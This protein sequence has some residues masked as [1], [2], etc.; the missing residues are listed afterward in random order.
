MKFRLPAVVAISLIL[1]STSGWSTEAKKA[2]TPET[3]PTQITEPQTTATP[4]P[5]PA[6]VTKPTPSVEPV[7]HEEV[8]PRATSSEHLFGLHAALSVPHPLSAGLD[9]VHSSRYFSLGVGAGSFGL[10]ISDTDVSIK[11]TEFALRW[12]PFAG[13]FYVGALLGNQNIT[14]EKTE[15]IQG[16]TIIGK[17]EV[18]SS[19]ITPNVGWMWGMDNGGFFA[20]MEL[21]FQSPSNV[22][23]DFTSNA[24]ATI[25]LQP[26]YQDL[27][28]DVIKQGDDIGNKGLPHI[29]L[30]KVGWLF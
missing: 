11:N 25:Q 19:Y 7:A 24:D 17:A 15:I 26:E 20:S 14:A 4:P 18:K 3:K 1:S 2:T 6:P 9:Y 5:A 12:H 22:K 16:Q 8:T 23:T 28:K 13:S 29:V 30:I 10:K 27:R 21:G